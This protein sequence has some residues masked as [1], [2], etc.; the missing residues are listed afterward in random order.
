MQGQG[1]MIEKRLQK[2]QRHRVSSGGLRTSLA[3]RCGA[4]WY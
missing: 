3:A 1:M 4:R 2:V